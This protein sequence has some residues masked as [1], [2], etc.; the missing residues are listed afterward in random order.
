MFIRSILKLPYAINTC[1]FCSIPN[2]LSTVT[3][4]LICH[5]TLFANA[6]TSQ[7]YTTQSVVASELPGDATYKTANWWTQKWWLIENRVNF[8]LND[9]RLLRDKFFLDTIIGSQDSLNIR[10]L[11]NI[12]TLQNDLYYYYNQLF[13][14]YY[15][16][17]S[18]YNPDLD[19]HYIDPFFSYPVRMTFANSQ[20]FEIRQDLLGMTQ[21][22]LEPEAMIDIAAFGISYANDFRTDWLTARDAIIRAEWILALGLSAFYYSQNE[23]NFGF[24]VPLYKT[25]H[26]NRW[27]GVLNFRGYGID[28][29]PRLETGLI[30]ETT[31]ARYSLLMRH[32]F[33]EKEIYRFIKQTLRLQI[34]ADLFS[35]TFFG[36]FFKMQ[37]KSIFERSIDAD[38]PLKAK[39]SDEDMFYF[40]HEYTI[41]LSIHRKITDSARDYAFRCR[42]LDF[43]INTLSL[44]I[45]ALVFERENGLK[46]LIRTPIIFRAF[47]EG[48]YG[49]P[50]T[51]EDEDDFDRGRHIFAGVHIEW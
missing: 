50:F 10:T 13:F 20:F 46:P 36:N 38:T 15:P 37:W 24:V 4:L 28:Q 42:F 49:V 9:I 11:Y 3:F 39:K 21:S 2:V 18:N 16:Q 43:R 45:P 41:R 14:R 27:A 1:S 40:L 25:M 33:G 32:R 48:G 34:E 6:D 5:C 23:I 35:R 31:M 19:S 30:Y 26:N 8:Y 22:D 44:L 12:K 29:S 7:F 17:N 51:L 47:F